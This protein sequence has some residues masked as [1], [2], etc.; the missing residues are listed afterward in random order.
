MAKG[1]APATGHLGQ[2]L[3]QALGMII[4][5]TS[6]VSAGVREGGPW[7]VFQRCSALGSLLGESMGALPATRLRGPPIGP[8]QTVTCKLQTVPLQ[9]VASLA[10]QAL[11]FRSV[12]LYMKGDWKEFAHSFQM[13]SW[14]SK[15]APCPICDI[16]RDCMTEVHPGF[17]SVDGMEWRDRMHDDYEHS[18]R[19]REVRVQVVNEV[20]R[21]LILDVM[22]HSGAT[23]KLPEGDLLVPSANVPTTSSFPDARLPFEAVFWRYSRDAKG[24]VIDWLRG[25]CP[26][27]SAELKTSPATCL[28]VDEMH[29]LHLGVVM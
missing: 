26:L 8:S 10:G 6:V 19:L 2:P 28:A 29:T 27:F 11:P 16:S 25:R 15:Y 22:N 21:K 23:Q 5:P 13:S 14:A 18:C 9:D 1:V 17:M 4:A 3:G 7:M 20:D 24:V 12:V